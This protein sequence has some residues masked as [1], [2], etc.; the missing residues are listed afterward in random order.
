M[1]NRSTPARKGDQDVDPEAFPAQVRYI[2]PP[3]CSGS[4]PE[5]SSQSDRPRIPPGGVIQSLMSCQNQS[6]LSPNGSG[7][8]YEKN[9]NNTNHRLR[10]PDR[11]VS[12]PGG[13]PTCAEPL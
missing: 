12:C 3:V 5:T 8:T 2:T 13:G 4:T 1:E 6:K 9:K 11:M 7:S 10:S